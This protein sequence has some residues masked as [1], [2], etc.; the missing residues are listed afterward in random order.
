[1]RSPG[2]NW[3][4]GE[5]KTPLELAFEKIFGGKDISWY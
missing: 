5:I 4:A 1:M 2:N 3:L